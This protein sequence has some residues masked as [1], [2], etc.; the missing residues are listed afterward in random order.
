M[1]NSGSESFL[2]VTYTHTSVSTQ[3]CVIVQQSTIYKYTQF[4]LITNMHKITLKTSQ[5]ILLTTVLV[6]Y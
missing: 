3:I 1:Y 6:Q 2:I 4:I 5:Y